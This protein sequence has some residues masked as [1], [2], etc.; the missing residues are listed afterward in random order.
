MTIQFTKK[1][2]LEIDAVLHL[3]WVNSDIKLGSAPVCLSF[4]RP[5][6]YSPDLNPIEQVWQIAHKEIAYIIF[7][8]TLAK[9]KYYG[10]R[11]EL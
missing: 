7:F 5:Q 3:A 8:A 9:L 2:L 10:Y 11:F 4:I 6:P 1:Q